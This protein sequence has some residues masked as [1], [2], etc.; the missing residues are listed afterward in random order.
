MPN[1][2]SI[3]E[4]VSGKAIQGVRDAEA[5]L[6]QL[7]EQLK[8]DIIAVNEL[9]KALSKNKGFNDF[10]ANMA[11]IELAQ[12]RVAKAALATK[13]QEERLASFRATE[14]ARQ[15]A[16]QDRETRNTNE[17]IRAY[18]ALSAQ[19]TRLRKNA[20]DVGVQF[21]V[22]S[23]QFREA[24]K[25]VVNLDRKLKDID[26]RLGVNNRNVGNY[27]NS[28]KSGIS[29][30]IGPFISFYAV[31]GLLSKS[32][33]ANK[34]IE[35]SLSD[36][37]R[38]AQLTATEGRELVAVFEKFD[39]RTSVKGL[40]D[41]AKIGGQ[42]G[43]AKGDLEGFTRSIDQL[44]IVLSD[45]I[46]GGAEAVATAIGKI[47]GVFDVQKK[48]NVDI[49]TAYNRTG[50]AI[51]GLGQSGLATGEFL[52]DFTQRVAGAAKASNISLPI[53]L[54]YGSV[55]EEAGSSAEVAG[56]SLNKLIGNLSTK[57]DKFFAIAKLADSSLTLK[58]FTKVINKDAN[59]ALQ[60][61]FKGLNAGNPT[62]TAFND[63]L[64]TIGIKAGPSKNAILSL[65]QGQE[66][67]SE[68]IK[69]S[70]KDYNDADKIAEQFA[71][72]NDNL[73][74]SIDKLDNAFNKAITGGNISKFF[75]SIVDGLTTA[76]IKFDKF[77]NSKSWNEFKHR[78]LDADGG[79]AF[80]LVN[81]FQTNE[82]NTNSN[83]QFLYPTGGTPDALEKKLLGKGKSFLDSYLKNLKKT[84]TTADILTKEYEEGVKSG[85]YV[86]EGASVQDYKTNAQRAKTYYDDVLA[87]YKKFGFD[88]KKEDAK[89]D[90]SGLGGNGKKGSDKDARDSAAA[91]V[92]AEI[93]AAKEV[94]A[95][96]DE[97]SKN[98]DFSLDSR[99]TA[100]ERYNQIT[101]K[102]ADL[103]AKKEIVGKKNTNNE[104]V[105]IQSE[106]ELKRAQIA[107]DGGKRLKEINITDLNENKR[108]ILEQNEKNLKALET[109]RDN[110]LTNLTDRYNRGEI[111][112]K[113]YANKRLKIEQDYTLK[114]IKLQLDQTDAA[115]KAAKARG[116]NVGDAEKALAELRLKYQDQIVANNKVN[117]DAII[118]QGEDDVEKRKK[119]LRELLDFV[120]EVEQGIY[121]LTTTFINAG[122]EN[123]INKL[124]GEKAALEERKNL[125]IENVN[126]SVLSE[127]DKQDRIAIIEAQATNR[128]LA[129]DA[130][131]AQEKRKQAI[132]D[133]IAAITQATINGA[134]A[135]GKA[136]AQVGPLG[137][138]V[139][140]GII[141]ATAIQIATITAQP[142]PKFAAGT[143]NAPEGFAHVGER[144]AEGRINP[145]GSFELT[146]AKT[147]LTY[148]EKGTKIIPNHDLVRMMAKPE[149]SGAVGGKSWDVAAIINSNNK[150]ADRIEKAVKNIKVQSTIIT[151]RGFMSQTARM[152]RYLTSIK[153]NFRRN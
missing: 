55:L 99:L 108:I 88:K 35:D 121:E 41:I 30:L 127:Q 79:D 131:I 93:N 5:A 135:V 95:V 137:A 2:N 57:R 91:L 109:Q 129:L 67:L 106:L 33:K 153:K 83:Q 116:E 132:A 66:K 45:E 139:I 94:Q 39:T 36:V 19:L 60:L 151:E 73:A 72:K 115:I 148:L 103:E 11:K 9:N 125:E 147:T 90:N 70:N 145:D 143:N 104:L 98:I 118:N 126:E 24:A 136:L 40:L 105:A 78:L 100:F 65:A 23:R 38:T 142:I 119:K 53:I 37:R 146:P 134:L 89:T 59:Q 62:L 120:G 92:Q 97:Q 113:S 68:K 20:Q 152:D 64:D 111:S 49:E 13:L 77:V 32:I 122:F 25:E 86:E 84:Y 114:Y 130:R 128:Q 96:Y 58:E 16:R 140:P 3:D 29:N 14:A 63:R 61:F 110:E 81:S 44:S 112:E 144:G 102:I 85:R 52:Q 46:P 4:I 21:G 43:I 18:A 71:L 75:K 17:N 42:L 124:E 1:S 74:G 12:Q 6:K 107:V 26:N 8:K 138:F 80:E 133:K 15:K 28:F 34:E 51:L 31:I 10:N 149:M 22:N 50:S 101:N 69:I 56:T 54:A 47:N 27:F 7:Y 141:A 48:D 82:R 123:R 150:S 87:L 76:L 117:S